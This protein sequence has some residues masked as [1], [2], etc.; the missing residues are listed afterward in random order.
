MNSK[1]NEMK[2]RED[3]LLEQ[4]SLMKSQLKFP[5]VPSGSNLQTQEDADYS[6]YDHHSA[7]IGQLEAVIYQQKDQLIKLEEEAV[8]L[9]DSIDQ[10]NR[11]SEHKLE[12]LTLRNQNLQELNQKHEAVSFGQEH[13]SFSSGVGPQSKSASVDVER[14]R[15]QLQHLELANMDLKHQIRELEV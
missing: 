2:Q 8:V 11:E 9:K 7:R 5:T 3:Q 12:L 13:L 4:I 6:S 10:K 14:M 15:Q 1:L